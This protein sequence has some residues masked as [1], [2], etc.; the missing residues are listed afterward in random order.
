M[1]SSIAIGWATTRTHWG[2]TMIGSFSTRARIISN[3]NEPDPMTIEAR[4]S[5]VGTPD[6]RRMR[7]T[8]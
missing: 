1:T 7:P 5:M 8:S 2:V 6:S 3:D 4:N